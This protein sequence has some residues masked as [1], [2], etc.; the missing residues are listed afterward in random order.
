MDKVV[1]IAKCTGSGV[2]RDSY[3]TLQVKAE[4]EGQSVSLP[5]L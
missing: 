5:R 3:S 1:F 4:T 2:S